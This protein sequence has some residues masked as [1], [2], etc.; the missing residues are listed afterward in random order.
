LKICLARSSSP[1]LTVTNIRSSDIRVTESDWLYWLSWLSVFDFNIAGTTGQVCITPLTPLD[2]L[3]MGILVPVICVAQLMIFAV[4][5][6]IL[7]KIKMTCGLAEV[8][9]CN[10][11]APIEHSTEHFGHR[12]G[13]SIGVGDWQIW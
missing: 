12:Q 6:A 4:I 10:E 3:S 8:Q 5:H 7:W 2:K 13:N 9:Q 11:Y 1:D